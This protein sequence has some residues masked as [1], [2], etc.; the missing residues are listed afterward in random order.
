MPASDQQ[1]LVATPGSIAATFSNSDGEPAAPTGAVTVTVTR[2]AGTP[3]T[4]G[5]PT[6]DP[7]NP[8]RYSATIAAGQ[9]SQV[10]MLTAVWAEGGFTRVT[11][12]HE[13]VGGYWFTI[14]EA[15]ASDET[16]GDSATYTDREIRTV[17]A[18]VEQEA[19]EIMAT[20][21]VPRFAE[22]RIDGNGQTT[23]SVPN[24]RLRA[25]LSAVVDGV[26]IN[27]ADV[28]IYDTGTM[29]RESGWPIGERNVILRYEHGY[30]R[31]NAELKRAAMTRLRHRLN[32]ARTGVPDR[33]VNFSAGD[34]GT[35][36]LA[37][38]GMFATGIPEVDATYRRYSLRTPGIA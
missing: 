37:T 9:I 20:A 22:E 14:A 24:T 25:L 16:L 8:A 38:A 36:Q 35:F 15:R 33:A 23:I 4:V 5:S 10:D 27:T 1:L 19:E 32:F 18:E 26:A 28:T 31:P 34:G 2:A 13:I 30:D 11:T 21:W 7:T 6:V 17:R 3:V 12:R 29:H